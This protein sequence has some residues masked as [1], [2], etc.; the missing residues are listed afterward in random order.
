MTQTDTMATP[1]ASWFLVSEENAPL[2][3]LNRSKDGATPTVGLELTNGAKYQSA[4]VVDFRELDPV[5]G[6]KR[7][8][9]VVRVLS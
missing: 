8:S 4:M 9:V 6:I 7:F 5:C 2:G 1:T 3:Q